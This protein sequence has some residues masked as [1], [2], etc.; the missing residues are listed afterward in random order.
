MW[1]PFKKEPVTQEPELNLDS[2]IVWRCGEISEQLSKL[3][4]ERHLEV[5]SINIAQ[6]NIAGIDAKISI[7]TKELERL[8]GR[9]ANGLANKQATDSE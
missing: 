9:I 7:K 5:A 1:N 3:K 2:S 6:S 8:L 4:A